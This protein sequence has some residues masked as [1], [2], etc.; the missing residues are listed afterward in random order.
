MKVKIL[1]AFNGDSIH[2]SF[3]DTEGINRNILIDGGT[4]PVYKTDRDSKGKPAYGVLKQTI[5]QIR[6][7]GQII[8]L[9]IL[10]HI[11]DDHIGGIIKWF[12]DD[13]DAFKLVSKVWFNS[14][15]LIAEYMNQPENTNLNIYINPN[16][17]SLTSINQ[18]IEFGKYIWD[19]NI[20]ERQI[21]IQGDKYEKYGLEF[22]ILSPDKA[23]LEKLLSE[24]K[25]KESDL[26]TAGK[27]NDYKLS[28]KDHIQNDKFTEDSAYPNGSSIAFILTVNDKNLL[29]LGDSHPSIVVEGLQRFGYSSQNPIKAEIVKLSHHGSRGNTSKELLSYINTKKFIISTNGDKDEHPHKQLL[30]RIISMNSD[31]EIHFNY[32]ERMKMIFSAQDR[33]DFPNFQPIFIDNEFEL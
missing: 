19:N 30:A 26:L 32:E 27:Q 16:K 21:F 1:K 5:D 25:K 18:G 7:D 3:K 8:D 9:L 31:C 14:G 29:F 6:K 10:T 33:L 13:K 24:W 28:L 15:G 12:D 23:K 20:W 4:K 22:K 17:T 11:D 2:I